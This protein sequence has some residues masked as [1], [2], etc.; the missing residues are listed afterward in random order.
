MKHAIFAP[1]TFPL[2]ILAAT[3]L[4]VAAGASI[5]APSQRTF[6]A[7]SGDDANPDCSRKL[8]CRNFNAAIAQTKPGGEMVIL[9]TAG[10]GPM[11]INKSIKVIG[12]S[13]VYG[14]ISVLG[15]AGPPPPPTTGVVINA[16]ST[17]VVT[18]RGLDIAG[19]PGGAPLPLYGIDV[20]NVGTLHIEKSSISNF[21]DPA[22]ACINVAPT[23]PVIVYVDDSFLRECRTGINANGTAVPTSGDNLVVIADHTQIERG[24]ATSGPTYGLW[25]HG[26]TAA[27][28]RSSVISFQ[29]VG[30]QMDNLA[31][32]NQSEVLLWHSQIL[33]FGTGLNVNNANAGSI[34]MATIAGSQ[35]YGGDD[36]I[37]VSHT[38]VGTAYAGQLKITDSFFQQI[39]NGGI[40]LSTGANA[41]MGADL[42]RSQVSSVGTT[43]ISLTA[44][45]TS[46]I[47]FHMRD[48]TLTNAASAL[49]RTAGTSSISVTLIR[50]HLHNSITAVDHGRG[51]IRMEQTNVSTNQKSLVNN[52][53]GDIVS[54][55]NNWI[56]DNVDAPGPVYITPNIIGLQ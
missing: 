8:P 33:A 54:A 19:V 50:S 16:A 37:V 32:N 7:S 39:N 52:G 43:A 46:G 18:L 35:F 31:P 22:G 26:F 10:Y 29:D 13:G 45:G 42:V 47:G 36:G 2:A 14:G 23:A 5:A 25:V 40:T 51:R 17:D 38:A 15:G 11:V 48:S 9:D 4:L 12:P 21:T 1:R 56:V 30:I 24:R 44:G 55:G 3:A 41:A 27:S 34:P 49:L 20:Q 6:V 28:V 53:S